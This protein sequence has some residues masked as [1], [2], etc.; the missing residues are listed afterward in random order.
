MNYYTKKPKKHIKIK[1]KKLILVIITIFF[2]F[3]SLLYFFDRSILPALI[4]IAEIEMKREAT[5]IIQQTALDIYSKYFN[6]DDVMIIEKDNEG[7]ITMVR[8][9]TVKLNY[10]SSKLILECNKKIDELENLGIKIPMGYMTNNSVTHNLGPKINIKMEQV[11]NIS[12]NYE[13]VFESAGINQTRHKI[14]LNVK[15]NMKVIIPLNSEE[16][17]VTCQI[18]I[19]ETIIVGKIPDTALE[20]NKQ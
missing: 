12:S 15:L 8:A 4:N 5:D 6:Y 17:E 20:F 19:A 1:H 18:P 11:G 16:V 3:N 9:D 2:V 7:N 10:L 14:Y 13:S